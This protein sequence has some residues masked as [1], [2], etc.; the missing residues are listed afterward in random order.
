MPVITP[1]PVVAVVTTMS[2]MTVMIVVVIVTKGEDKSE[3]RPPPRA[4]PVGTVTRIPRP[5]CR[6]RIKIRIRIGNVD[7]RGHILGRTRSV[8]NLRSGLQ[9]LGGASARHLGRGDGLGTRGRLTLGLQAVRLHRASLPVL[10]RSPFRARGACTRQSL[11]RTCHDRLLRSSVLRSD[12][13]V[14]RVCGAACVLSAG[15]IPGDKLPGGAQHEGVL[16]RISAAMDI[17]ERPNAS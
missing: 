9:R 6:T 13:T 14:V 1:M 11:E 7:R 15:V 12:S 2:V 5:I 16:R 10:K 3:A 17:S 8:D 4:A